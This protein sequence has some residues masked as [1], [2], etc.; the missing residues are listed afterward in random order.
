MNDLE[1]IG[2]PLNDPSRS[3]G[4]SHQEPKDFDDGANDL[5]SLYGKEARSHDEVQI[6]ALKED[7]DGVLIFVC[8]HSLPLLVHQA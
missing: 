3:P 7:M 8:V 5:W 2:N 1:G 6:Q 4:E